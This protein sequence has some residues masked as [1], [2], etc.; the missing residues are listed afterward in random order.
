MQL[1]SAILYSFSQLT[2]NISA[3]LKHRM[4]F[5]KMS[6]QHLVAKVPESSMS[7]WADKKEGPCRVIDKQ[8]YMSAY[9]TTAGHHLQVCMAVH[10]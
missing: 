6:C 9:V 4:Q 5:L 7:G 3:L 2:V 1:W 10:R 8:S